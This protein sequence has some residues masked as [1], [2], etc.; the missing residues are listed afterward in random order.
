MSGVKGYLS[1]AILTLW[2][3]ISMAVTTLYSNSFNGSGSA[4]N[5]LPNGTGLLDVSF[6]PPPNTAD[7]TY[8]LG[9]GKLASKCVAKNTPPPGIP[10]NFY[11]YFLTSLYSV[12]DPNSPSN[13]LTIS[14]NDQII[15]FNI[16]LGYDHDVTSK[17]AK[18][19]AKYYNTDVN[20]PRLGWGFF[21][22]TNHGNSPVNLCFGVSANK[23]VA[24]VDGLSQAS[25]ADTAPG[26]QFVSE[27]ELADYHPGQKVLVTVKVDK[28]N[29]T[30]IYFINGIKRA[31]VHLDGKLPADDFT[32]VDATVTSTNSPNN[33]ATLDGWQLAWVP[34]VSQLPFAPLSLAQNKKRNPIGLLDAMADQVIYGLNTAYPTSYEHPFNS[35]Y[36]NNFVFDNG[37]NYNM[38]LYGINVYSR[39][40]IP[41]IDNI[42][43]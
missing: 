30:G 21:A 19:Q 37:T 13:A 17:A 7:C 6:V 22:I 18:M 2:S 32:L 27:K 31:V 1:V 14:T 42:D 12:A 11:T 23:I 28:V 20:D 3:S 8:T 29:R 36:P 10:G 16:A 9:G 4:V 43:H 24:Y 33:N 26:Y 15:I 38:A 39:A 34:A 41:L 25:S 35:W 40:Y 5:A